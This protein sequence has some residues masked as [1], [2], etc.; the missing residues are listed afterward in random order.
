MT[1]QSL[2]LEVHPDLPQNSIKNASMTELVDIEHL[3]PNI[4]C[5]GSNLDAVLKTRRLIANLAMINILKDQMKSSTLDNLVREFDSAVEIFDSRTL[6][7]RIRS[8][9]TYLILLRFGAPL[10]TIAYTACM[11]AVLYHNY[12]SAVQYATYATAA[13]AIMNA[14]ALQVCG[15]LRRGRIEL[16]LGFITPPRKAHLVACLPLAYTWTMV[17]NSDPFISPKMKNLLMEQLREAASIVTRRVPR[18]LTVPGNSNRGVVTARCGS[19]G[20]VLESYA[21]WIA[22]PGDTTQ[23]DLASS[24]RIVIAALAKGQLDRLP[25]SKHPKHSARFFLISIGRTIGIVAMGLIPIATLVIGSRLLHI[26][27]S[28]AIGTNL[29]LTAIAFAIIFTLSKLDTVGG[30]SITQMKDL[31]ST[32]KNSKI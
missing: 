27:I 17:E 30:E 19:A 28:N 6:K 10:V 24:L 15:Y 14:V 25:T 26:S 22:L 31:I 18:D 21:L 1:G 23:T 32:F 2:S 5:D 20:K 8:E 4:K 7:L 16:I 9:K 3:L 12:S 11:L 29:S 13:L